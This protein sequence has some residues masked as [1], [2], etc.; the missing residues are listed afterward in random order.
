MNEANAAI[1]FLTLLIIG[2]KVNHMTPA[3]C[4]TIKSAFIGLMIVVFYKFLLFNE[5]YFEDFIFNCSLLAFLYF[6][7]RRLDQWDNRNGV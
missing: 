5:Q 4:M 6:D 3:T 1:L 2:E 7:R